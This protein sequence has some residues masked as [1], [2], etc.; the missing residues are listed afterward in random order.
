[1][2]DHNIVDLQYY[3]Y[4]HINI[5]LGPLDVVFMH[6][7][8]FC[9]NRTCAENNKRTTPVMFTK[10]ISA[11]KIVKMVLASRYKNVRM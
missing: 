3:I 8:Q 6:H 11:N 4:K 1:M 5:I 9:F 2:I 10:S 7:K